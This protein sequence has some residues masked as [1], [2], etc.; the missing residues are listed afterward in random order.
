MSSEIREN[1]KICRWIS[2]IWGGGPRLLQ[3]ANLVPVLLEHFDDRI[4][5][6]EVAGADRDHDGSGLCHALLDPPAP[7]GI[8]LANERVAKHGRGGNIAI[9]GLRD[10]A[11][12]A[13][14]PC[15]QH[16]PEILVHRRGGIDRPLQES[17]LRR[18]W[19]AVEEAELL[20]VGLEF[21]DRFA[22]RRKAVAE[23]CFDA[24]VALQAQFLE[25]VLQK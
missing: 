12:I 9:E 25:L 2:A 19:K 6:G 8:A 23:D 3:P 17:A 7:I 5:T 11:N 21:A 22:L 20:D 24:F 4:F 13:A 14:R 1:V 15:A 18:L 10:A 16:A